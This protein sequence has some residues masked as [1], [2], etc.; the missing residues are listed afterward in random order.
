[1]DPEG[2]RIFRIL[3]RFGRGRYGAVY[4]SRPIGST[5]AQDV[6]PE[7]IEGAD[8]AWIEAAADRAKRIRRAAEPVLIVEE[9]PIYLG[10]ERWALVRERFEGCPVDRV[11]DEGV[12]LPVVLAVAI[13]DQVARAISR[14]GLSHGELDASQVSISA[15]GEVRLDG[16]GSRTDVPPTR[17]VQDLGRLLE[18]ILSNAPADDPL[19]PDAAR[20]AR[21]ML[22]GDVALREVFGRCRGIADQ[23]PPVPIAALG[24]QIAPLAVPEVEL[25]A[26]TGTDFEEIEPPPAAV[27]WDT[28]P[29]PEAD[30]GAETDA[31]TEIETALRPE[32]EPELA[33]RPTEPAGTY[34]LPAFLD[35]LDPPTG[36]A[37][38]PPPAPRARPASRPSSGPSAVARVL[39]AMST[40]LAMGLGLLLGLGAVAGG[41]LW[42]STLPDRPPDAP[43]APQGDRVSG[44]VGQG[45]LCTFAPGTALAPAEGAVLRALD[46]RTWFLQA[47]LPAAIQI[48]GGGASLTLDASP[49]ATAATVERCT[50]APSDPV[51]VP[52]GAEVSVRASA[53]RP[54]GPWGT[55]ARRAGSRMGGGAGTRGPAGGPG[56]GG[57]GPGGDV[58]RGPVPG[59]PLV[60]VRA[61]RGLDLAIALL[62]KH[63][64]L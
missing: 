16:V 48:A 62:R 44:A 41:L 52:R 47:E 37:A 46:D 55:A 35:T 36:A 11:L 60:G 33:G 53:S 43:A 51:M 14:S 6:V 20:L 13:I 63:T 61:G 1:M 5:F 54:T 10:G 4:L 49:V 38:T 31:V 19:R 32:P 7:L 23:G 58:V 28:V 2:A 27:E 12:A 50:T 17:D 64:G 8:P 25:D 21:E 29:F 15:A 3:G 42:W 30:P 57:A 24:A 56:R 45:V 59:H 39:R 40:V 9:P 26:L 34:S 22:A 18:R